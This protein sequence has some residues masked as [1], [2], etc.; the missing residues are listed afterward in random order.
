[1]VS[2]GEFA[3]DMYRGAG[4]KRDEVTEEGTPFVQ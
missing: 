2:L 4:I 1:M 3:T